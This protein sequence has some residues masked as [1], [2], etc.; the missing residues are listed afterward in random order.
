MYIGTPVTEGTQVPANSSDPVN[1]HDVVGYVQ[2]FDFTDLSALSVQDYNLITSEDAMAQNIWRKT[3]DG[4]FKPFYVEVVTTFPTANSAHIKVT[5]QHGSEI[6]ISSASVGHETFRPLFTIT[7]FVALFAWAIATAIIAALYVSAPVIWKNAGISEAGLN[8][9]FG[10]VPNTVI[11]VAII[12]V[13]GV[14]GYIYFTNKP[15]G[16]S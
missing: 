1:Y 10:G 6:V 13:V 7:M 5:E 3:R 8:L 9:L 15:K 11:A 4:G 2:E 12:A 16:G 14:L